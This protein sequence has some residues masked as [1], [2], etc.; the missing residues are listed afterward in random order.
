M[1][2]LFSIPRYANYYREQTKEYR[3]LVKAYGIRFVIEVTG[4]ASMVNYASVIRILLA[5][6]S[7]AGL[8][9]A[10]GAFYC[11]YLFNPNN[12]KLCCDDH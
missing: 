6:G 11:F 2:H 3:D 4:K 1:S 10:V 8:F 9:K 7:L 12:P 5:I